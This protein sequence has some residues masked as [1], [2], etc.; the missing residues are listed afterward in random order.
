M[1]SDIFAQ[2]A[3]VQIRMQQRHAAFV[4]S[5]IERQLAN[6]DIR[7]T[8][9]SLLPAFAQRL[10]RV[11][12]RRRGTERP[13]VLLTVRTLTRGEA[14]AGF[15]YL[16]LFF[17]PD[18]PVDTLT[19]HDAQAVREV[20]FALAAGLLA[21]RGPNKLDRVAVERRLQAWNPSTSDGDVRWIS[22]LK[23]RV[24]REGALGATPLS[25]IPKRLLSLL[26]K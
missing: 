15:H 11:A 6:D 25:R 21:R 22:R 7:D 14:F 23:Q 16:S 19:R 3:A 5:L 12:A 26:T 20:M 24:K 10:S 4:G 1:V 13:D 2:G 17:H 18:V 9:L 8:P